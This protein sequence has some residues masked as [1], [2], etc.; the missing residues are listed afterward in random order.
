VSDASQGPG[1][2]QAS[3]GKWYPPETHPS[4]RPGPAPAD[5]WAAAS[6]T[7]PTNPAN[8]GSPGSPGVAPD[9]QAQAGYAQ[10]GSGQAPYGQAPDPTAPGPA[11]Y[12]QPAYGQAPYGQATSGPPA[13][14]QAPYGQAPY[15]QAPYGQGPGYA[16]GAGAYGYGP[17]KTNGMAVASLVLSILGFICFLGLI[18]AG[19]AII[20]GVIARRK[21]RESGGAEKGDGLALAGIIVG[22]VFVALQIGFVALALVGSTNSNNT[23]NGLVRPPAHVLIVAP[24]A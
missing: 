11:P 5:P 4:A 12:G 8:L 17:P 16:A 3:D 14:G 15:G 1:W 24:P 7:S 18:S 20:L 23:N 9:P 10:P 22:A 19:A 6:P 2:W 13:Y 21:I